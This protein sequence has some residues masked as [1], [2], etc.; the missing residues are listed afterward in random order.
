MKISVN[1]QKIMLK[2]TKGFEAFIA[3]ERVMVC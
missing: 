1:V 2:R 3:D